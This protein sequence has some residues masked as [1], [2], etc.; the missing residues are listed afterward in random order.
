MAGVALSKAGEGEV[1]LG[2][3][4]EGG[5]GEH[6]GGR[7]IRRR[8]RRAEGEGGGRAGEGGGPL[9]AGVA[10]R[11]RA[12]ADELDDQQGRRTVVA[13]DPTPTR[14]IVGNRTALPVT[15]SGRAR[16]AAWTAL[17]PPAN[18]ASGPRPS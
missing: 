14:T 8:D 6:P 5:Q 13:P 7:P 12:G 4:H 17:A 10:G 2:C 3:N 11:E 15:K 1:A 18:N 9:D 16:P